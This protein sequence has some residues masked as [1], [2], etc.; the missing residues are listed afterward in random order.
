MTTEF[1][2]RLCLVLSLGEALLQS[3][4]QILTTIKGIKNTGLS[5][6][7]SSSSNVPSNVPPPTNIK[8]VSDVTNARKIVAGVLLFL[9]KD[10]RRRICKK[11]GVKPNLTYV[12]RS[13]IEDTQIGMATSGTIRD[14]KLDFLAAAFKVAGKEKNSLLKFLHKIQ[15]CQDDSEWQQFATATQLHDMCQTANQILDWQNNGEK[16]E[17]P[18]FNNFLQL[19]ENDNSDDY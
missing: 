17:H 19:V 11:I 15:N 1:D 14:D 12:R 2:H 16:G 13:T 10:L 4:P 9:Y 18:L 5:S 7:S 6:I 8:V 3:L